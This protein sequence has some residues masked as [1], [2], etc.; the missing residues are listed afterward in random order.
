MAVPVDD[1]DPESVAQALNV[2]GYIHAEAT[3]RLSIFFAGNWPIVR[4]RKVWRSVL[5]IAFA[6]FALRKQCLTSR[7]ATNPDPEDE[8]DRWEWSIVTNSHHLTVAGHRGS[9]ARSPLRKKSP[10]SRSA[11]SLQD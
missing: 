6:M 7:G 3:Q 8:N 5:P 9:S 1:P 11:W 2:G 4:R 10:Q